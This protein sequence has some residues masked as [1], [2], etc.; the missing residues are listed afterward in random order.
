MYLETPF[1]VLLRKVR[2]LVL[3]QPEEKV[4]AGLARQPGKQEH[5]LSKVPCRIL[6]LLLWSLQGVLKRVSPNRDQRLPRREATFMCYFHH[7][8]TE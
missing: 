5:S 6:P 4:P 8:A 7:P 3:I 1:H 2:Q